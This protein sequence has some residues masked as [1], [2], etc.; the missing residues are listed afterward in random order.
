MPDQDIKQLKRGGGAIALFGLPF[1]AMGLFA[2]FIFLSPPEGW[3]TA[4]ESWVGVLVGGIFTLVG[5]GLVFGRSGTILDRRRRV[6]TT[7]WGLLVPFSSTQYQVGRDALVS[8]SREVRRHKNRTY[9]VFPVRLTGENLD[10]SFGEPGSFDL[11]RRLAEDVAK[12]FGLAIHDRSGSEEVIREAGTLDESVQARARR[13][14]MATPL[15]AQPPRAVCTIQYGG[16]HSTTVIEIPPAGIGSG[17]YAGLIGALIFAG[18]V[19]F[20]F[21]GPSLKDGFNGNDW[22]FASFIGLFFMAIP[23]GGALLGMLSA[24]KSWYRITVSP[25]MVEVFRQGIFGSTTTNLSAAEIEEIETTGL[26]TEDPDALTEQMLRDARNLTEAQKEKMRNMAPKMIGAGK[27]MGRYSMDTGSVVI[28]SDRAS[29]ELGVQLK[30]PEKEWLRSVIVHVLTADV[31]G[32]P[33][34]S[35]PP[36]QKA[37]PASRPAPAAMP[38]APDHP[39]SP[40]KVQQRSGGLAVSL[41]GLAALIFVLY[42]NGVFT[43]FFP[44]EIDEPAAPPEA[45]H[46][47]KPGTA[48]A[49]S[50]PPAAKTDAFAETDRLLQQSLATAEQTYGPLHPAVAMALYQMGVT[51]QANKRPMEQGQAWLRALAILDTVP[52]KYLGEPYAEADMKMVGNNLG[53]FKEIVARGLGDYYWDQYLYNDSYYHYDLAYKLAEEAK[54]DDAER[55]RRLASSSAGIMATACT[56]GKWEIADYAMAEL[57]ERMRTVSPEEQK[58]LDYWV[59][60]G[61]PRLKKRKC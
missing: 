50:A 29:V 14:H 10:V 41:V 56:L 19:F 26:K 16:P 8:I 12:F 24:V 21:L 31:T 46:T 59:R 43:N 3:T 13:L 47:A 15:P 36:M 25:S 34:R 32:E 39:V 22:I 58:R 38:A 61:E 49:E 48:Q 1:L 20:M 7:W 44:E 57:K 4:G 55:N 33:A 40:G 60:T 53:D 51:Y 54:I 5:A 30:R 27:A 6:V 37:A 23:V 42:Q 11:S 9:E 52:K 35:A 28:R 45:P 18:F 17:H 2:S